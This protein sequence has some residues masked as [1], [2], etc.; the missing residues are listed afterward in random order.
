MPFHT[1]HPTPHHPTPPQ[2]N[3]A[4]KAAK[5]YTAED[6]GLDEDNAWAGRVFVNPPAGVQD[7][8]AIQVGRPHSG[9]LGCGGLGLHRQPFVA[10]Q[11]ALC[12]PW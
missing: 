7:G 10:Y 1:P 9:D 11:Y 3:E 4:V 12:S 2:A 6:D 8:K 5:I